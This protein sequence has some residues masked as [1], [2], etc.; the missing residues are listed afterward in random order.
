MPP[1][2]S[3]S[4]SPTATPSPAAVASAERAPV[5]V[6]PEP[7]PVE[8][9]KIQP[10]RR[11]A[12][13]PALAAIRT[14]PEEE[15][16]LRVDKQGLPLPPSLEPKV[17]AAWLAALPKRYQQKIAAF[18]RQHRTD[19]QEPCGGIGPLHIP[20]P[21]F[22]RIRAHGPTS[23]FASAEEWTASLTTAQRRYIARECAGGEER[24]SSDLCGD[25]TPLVVALDDQPIEF[26][27]GTHF[28]FRTGTTT[29]TDW[30][31]AETPWI[32]LDRNADG[33][34][35]RG[36]EL[37][38]SDTV[39]ANG[40]TARNG[41]AALADLDANH[42]GAIDAA[43]PAFARLVLWADRDADGTSGPGELAPLSAKIVSI[44]LANAV[45][46]RCD[47][48]GNCEGERSAL[49]WRDASGALHTG[50]VVDVYLPRRVA[51]PAAER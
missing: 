50:S 21:P 46:E 15:M 32:A 49:T 51:S 31:T 39:L 36:A 25:N 6:A 34:I 7:A 16:D 35:D 3:P 9:P 2:P 10:A 48:R 1:A 29:A 27:T 5:A 44:S 23:L 24:D 4:P 22:P 43:D 20:Y 47:A 13:R 42:D 45:R 38:G 40:A 30:P 37:F 17:Y 28:A 41:F 26:T 19:L 33:L 12:P 11:S 8:V 14:A 18:C